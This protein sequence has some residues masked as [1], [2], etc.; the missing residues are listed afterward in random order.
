[1]EVKKP[2]K[3]A[4]WQLGKPDK[5]SVFCQKPAKLAVFPPEKPDKMAV[6]HF[7]TVFVGRAD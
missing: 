7:G 5:M 2:A 1:M 4:V 6:F 3:L